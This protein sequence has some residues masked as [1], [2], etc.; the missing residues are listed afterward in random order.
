MVLIWLTSAALAGPLA[1]HLREAIA[2]N[3][4]RRPLY[5]AVTDG[6]SRPISRILLRQ[7]RIALL[8]SPLVDLPARRHQRAGIPLLEEDLASMSLTPP[9]Q[10]CRLPP[11]VLDGY[12]PLPMATVEAELRLSLSGEDNFLAV[13]ATGERWIVV[14]ETELG[15]GCMSRHLL[16]SIVAIAERAPARVAESEAAGLRDPSRLLRRVLRQHVRLLGAAE[17]LD[18]RAAPL[19]AEGVAILCQDVPPI[20]TGGSAT[21]AALSPGAPAVLADPEHALEGEG[22]GEGEPDAEGAEAEG[23]AEQRAEGDLQDGGDDVD[24]QADPRRP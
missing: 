19:Q 3:R 16:E 12:V 1:T 4:E 18:V 15:L 14:S 9:F 5:A 7:E 13:A 20:P 23:E 6:E 2:L 10:A 11:P 8:L 24:A 17:R 21:G 22:D